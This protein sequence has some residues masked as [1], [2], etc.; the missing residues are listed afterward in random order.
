MS[1]AIGHNSEKFAKDQLRSIIERIE[2]LE[3]DKDAIASDIKD[4]F[5]EAKGQGYCVKTLRRVITMRKKDPAARNEE[6]ALLETYMHAL[7]M[8]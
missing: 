5:T 8:E 2:N 3:T 1:E 7:G 4:V 6:A